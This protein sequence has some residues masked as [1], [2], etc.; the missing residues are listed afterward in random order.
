MIYDRVK[1]GCP[2][3]L[4]EFALKATLLAVLLALGWSGVQAQEMKGSDFDLKITK[5]YTVHSINCLFGGSLSESE[6][7]KLRLVVVEL[8]GF[9]HKKLD[10][11]FL[12]NVEFVAPEALMPNAVGKEEGG[13]VSWG[14]CGEFSKASLLSFDIPA[15]AHF[16]VFL[17]FPGIPR[18]AKKF[19][20]GF[21]GE[22]LGTAI[23][24][25]PTGTKQ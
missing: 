14:P 8:S 10:S 7:G 21:G 9:A 6:D 17:A 12:G 5:A 15:E 4:R 18:E 20:I 2:V 13:K 1:G 3:K 22:P 11:M 16:K 19:D 23:L 24:E 25:P